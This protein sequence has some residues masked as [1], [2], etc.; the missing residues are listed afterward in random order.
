M[1][2]MGNI[3]EKGVSN[4]MGVVFWGGVSS[5]LELGLSSLYNYGPKNV[6]EHSMRF[7]DLPWAS[8]NF[9]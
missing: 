1:R 3:G 8:M 2:V 4:L 7:H 5:P 9:Y 6:M